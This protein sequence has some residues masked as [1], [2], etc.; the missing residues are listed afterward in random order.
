MSR[1]LRWAV[2]WS[3]GGLVGGCVVEMMRWLAFC[4]V[5]NCFAYSCGVLNV[6]LLS[7]CFEMF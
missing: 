2:R 5:L 6:V 7:S 4:D 3:R 1:V